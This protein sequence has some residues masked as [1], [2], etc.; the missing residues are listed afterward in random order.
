MKRKKTKM[1]ENITKQVEWE[2]LEGG[3]SLIKTKYL[4]RGNG[5]GKEQINIG[6]SGQKL[7][8]LCSNKDEQAVVGSSS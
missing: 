3:I 8:D 1:P 6:A 2:F 7:P 4:E 5:N